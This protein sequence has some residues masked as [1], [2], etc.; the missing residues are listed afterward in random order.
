M[1]DEYD[2]NKSYQAQSSEVLDGSA[3]SINPDMDYVRPAEIPEQD[4]YHA[5]SFIEKW[6]FCQDAK[7][8]GVQYFLTAVFT[9]I[10]G[11]ILSWLM[12]LQLG[13]PELAGFMTAEHYYQFVTMHG[14][15]MVVYFL[16]ALFLGGFGNYL[17]PL[18]VGAR[19]MVF[20]YVNMLSFWMFFIAVAVLMASFFVPG[21][22]TGAGWTLYPPQTILEGTP[23]SGM[24]ILLMLISLSL[25]VI[26]FT[27]GG[28]NYMITILHGDACNDWWIW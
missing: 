8:I 19:D 9:G 2:N 20:P 12:R 21:G 22:P 4:L 10:V 13:F 18:M 11:L 23:G 17:I 6:I 3:G 1:S 14:M 26:G 27:M 15:I 5:H 28:L 7:V 24:G 25:F 16:T